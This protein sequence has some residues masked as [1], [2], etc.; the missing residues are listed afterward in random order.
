MMSMVEH[1]RWEVQRYREQISRLQQEKSR[2]AQN[3][4][5]CAGNIA[6]ERQMMSS[7]SS[8]SSVQS[9]LRSITRYEQDQA[10]CDDRIANV[11]RQIADAERNLARASDWLSREEVRES[12]RQAEEH[13]R[14]MAEISASVLANQTVIA[15][16]EADVASIKK[17][18][19]KMTVL[20]L[21]ANPVVTDRLGLD[22]EAHLILEMIRKSE[23]RD[24]IR[25]VSRWAVRPMDVLQAINEEKPTVVHF[26]GHGAPN[27]DI[28][29]QNDAGGVKCVTPTAM[30]S[31]IATAADSVRLVFFNSCFSEE[32]AR[33]V[34]SNID[35]A[36]GMRV[37]I[38][39]EAARVFAAQ[40]YSAIGFGKDVDM[41]FKQGKAALLLEGIPE[42]NTPVLYARAGIS[43]GGI[44]LVHNHVSR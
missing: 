14:V 36:I 4:A 8:A 44:K 42:E 18:M 40:F 32:Q 12:Q 34:V 11:E 41:A 10:R 21:A 31:A 30:T 26:S 28:A 38:G 1:Y 37:S 16:V 43:V 15:D 20:F 6:R 29:L 35:V 3:K 13:R 17:H 24:S 9:H 39:D 25:F 23:Y 7:S 2:H 5:R 22:E 33:S 27:G 19:N